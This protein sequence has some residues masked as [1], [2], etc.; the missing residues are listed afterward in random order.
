[1]V[2]HQSLSTQF[3][4]ARL[5]LGLLVENVSVTMFTA[6][7]PTKVLGGNIWGHVESVKPT[8]MGTTVFL[9]CVSCSPR[10]EPYH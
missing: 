4:I 2:T 1:M 5:H 8:T 3:S 9:S 10:N 7:I 6:N